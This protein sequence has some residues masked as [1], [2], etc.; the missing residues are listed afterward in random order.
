VLR[1]PP[2]QHDSLGSFMP[3]EGSPPD[4]LEGDDSD[5]GN[6]AGYSKSIRSMRIM[7]PLTHCVP[8]GRAPRFLRSA[9][10]LSLRQGTAEG[11][12]SPAAAP[13]QQV[14]RNRGRRLGEAFRVQPG[15]AQRVQVG[16]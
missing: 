11:N 8:E 15:F 3:V 14:C 1:T 5:W 13:P 6:G 9:A 10:G 2:T 16:R 12:R 7:R 4:L